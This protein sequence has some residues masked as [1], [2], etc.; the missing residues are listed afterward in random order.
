M[1]PL[2]AGLEAPAFS[3]GS[4]RTETFG[5]VGQATPP[6]AEWVE[7]PVQGPGVS[8]APCRGSTGNVATEPSGHL[9]PSLGHLC[10]DP[11]TSAFGVGHSQCPGLIWLESFQGSMCGYILCPLRSPGG[12]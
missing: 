6:R 1:N 10:P 8:R 9:R 2:Q 5:A 4:Q 7:W 3:P 12:L 11:T